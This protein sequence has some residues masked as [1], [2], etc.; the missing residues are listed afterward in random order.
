[1]SDFERKIFNFF[2]MTFLLNV[3]CWILKKHTIYIAYPYLLEWMIKDNVNLEGN[4]KKKYFYT[5]LEFSL[6]TNTPP[7]FNKYKWS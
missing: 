5:Y 2:L 1:M 7:P 6:N 3:H 4:Q